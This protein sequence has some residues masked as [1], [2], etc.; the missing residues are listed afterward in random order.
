M[1]FRNAVQTVTA[2]FLLSMGTAMAAP[3]VG[4]LNFTG[5]VR[6]TDTLIDYLP[7]EGAPDGDLFVLGP[8]VQEGS[9]VAIAN[10][11]GDILDLDRTLYPV[12]PVDVPGFLTLAGNIRFDLTQILP[13]T[14]GQ[15]Q[16][17]APPAAG[18][19]CT[20]P[21]LSGLGVSPFNLSNQTASSS[22]AAFEVRGI[23]VNTLTG[24][25]TPG[26]GVFSTQFSTKSFQQVLQELQTE[27]QVQ[28]SYSAEFTAVPEPSAWALGLIGLGLI[29]ARRFSTRN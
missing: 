9:F 17:A 7:P 8:L 13:G 18:Q 26:S 24:E 4:T 3:I 6:V 15:A 1:S 5:A 14:F 11:T 27:G 16:C 21:E 2:V 25:E 22:I 20:P 10:T 28:A 23:F 29:A 19:T 12:G